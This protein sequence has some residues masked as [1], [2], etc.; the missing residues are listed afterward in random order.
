MVNGKQPNALTN[1]ASHKIAQHGPQL[2]NTGL[3]VHV[4]Q[5]K[6]TPEST[7]RLWCA[8]ADM[9]TPNAAHTPQRA[10]QTPKNAEQKVFIRD[11]PQTTSEHCRCCVAASSELFA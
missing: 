6:Q 2:N 7:M 10:E 11:S 8:G 9:S 1:R 4:K 3:K 5:N